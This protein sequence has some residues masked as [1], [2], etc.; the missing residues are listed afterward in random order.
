M[1][2]EIAQLKN[3]IEQLKNENKKLKKENKQLRC[4]YVPDDKNS[5]SAFIIEC[6]EDSENYTLTTRCTTDPMW[7]TKEEDNVICIKYLPCADVY[8]YRIRERINKITLG[9]G[10][11]KCSDHKYII[12][13]KECTFD[14]LG[15]NLTIACGNT[16][17]ELGWYSKCGPSI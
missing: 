4:R 10:G 12:P 7:N 16:L 9:F 17:L 3:A 8:D 14:D 5:Q 11:H 13:K 6:E 2:S 1:E 15:F